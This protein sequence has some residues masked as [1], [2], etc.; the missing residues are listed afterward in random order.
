MLKL[1]NNYEGEGCLRY[2]KTKLGKA[3]PTNFEVPS[4]NSELFA[5]GSICCPNRGLPSPI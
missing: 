1:S 2:L 4:R 3:T 5:M